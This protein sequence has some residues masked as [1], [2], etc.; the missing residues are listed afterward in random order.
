MGTLRRI[1]VIVSVV[2]GMGCCFV[3]VMKI[4]R[5]QDPL[6]ADRWQFFVRESGVEDRKLAY[7]IADRLAADASHSGGWLHVSAGM[8][9]L[10]NVGMLIG[11]APA[12]PKES[13]AS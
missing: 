4:T 9:L 1:L 8:L 6:V 12:R 10:I 13:P 11:F 7:A 5:L 2:V 3:G